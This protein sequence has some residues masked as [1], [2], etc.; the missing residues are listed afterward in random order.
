VP[1]DVSLIADND[2]RHLARGIS[3][4]V[5]DWRTIGYS[6]A[7]CLIGDVPVEKTRQGFI[8]PAALFLHR[9]TTAG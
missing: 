2:L 8:R 6:A 1:D 4:C 9:M 5:P 7:H 3:A